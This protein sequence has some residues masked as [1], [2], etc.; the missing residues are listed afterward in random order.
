MHKNVIGSLTKAEGKETEDWLNLQQLADVELTSEM[1][2]CPIEDV[3]IVE[4]GDGWRASE[5]GTQSIRL[6]F[7]RP[8][9]IRRI[10]LEFSETEIERTQEIALTYSES[11]GN[12]REILRQ[13]W[14]FSPA[15]STSEIEDYRVELDNV[16]ALQLTID[17]DLGRN[18]SVG[19]LRRWLVA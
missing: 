9:K 5:P 8:Q 7:A 10:H 11:A 1:P 2:S 16:R 12:D 17:P 18:V 19:T 15:G 4:G 6:R 3:F 14:T 13:R